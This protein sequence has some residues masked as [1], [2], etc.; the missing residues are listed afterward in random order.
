M[1]LGIMATHP[2]Q[3]QV[4]WY[5]ALS[6]RP[7]VDLTVY[8]ALLP[9]PEQQGV[10]F[11]IDFAWDVPLLDGYR[12]EA[13]RNT[14]RTPS[15]RGFFSSRTPGVGSVLARDRPDAVIVSGW[16]ALPLLQ[17]VRACGHLGIP[18]LLRGESSGLFRRPWWAR[19]IHRRFLTRFAACLAIGEANR[20]FY[21]QNGV[22]PE[23]IFPVPYFADNDRFVE[24]AARWMPER[25]SIRRGWGFGPDD[26]CFLFAGKL[27]PKKRVLDF[28]AGCE[29]AR[30]SAPEIRALVVGAGEVE[31]EAR[32]FAERHDLRAVFAGFLNQ[33]E[34]SRA[35]VVADCLV[36]PSDYGET[37]GLVINE[38]ML[39]GL[40]S[41]VSDRVGCGP[42]LVDDG[43]TG[44]VFPFGDVDALARAMVET[45]A[46]EDQRREMGRRARLRVDAYSA[47]RAVEGT[48]D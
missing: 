18:C 3:Y 36:L 16:Q 15:L 26:I 5:R 37:W 14:A 40:P 32:R 10:D 45:A 13:L 46:R 33:S 28:L 38:A 6:A 41:I 23:R 27:V 21:L 44:R 20:E 1:K 11:G 2:V 29:I 12:W 19:A 47:E 7:G 39:H 8:F 17:A 34:I 9:T 30:R 42:D 25:A 4:P 24:Q 35:Y 48:L 31:V 22:S 43:V